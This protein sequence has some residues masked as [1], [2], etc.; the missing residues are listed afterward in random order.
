MKISGLFIIVILAYSGIGYCA[1][2]FVADEAA[3]STQE[4]IK[5]EQQNA[6]RFIKEQV[7]LLAHQDSNVRVT[8]AFT[9]D[10][11]NPKPPII[12]NRE[13]F[14][15]TALTKLLKNDKSEDVRKTSAF[16]ISRIATPK[17][18]DVLF[19]QY[20]VEKNE[21]VRVAMITGSWIKD[22]PHATDLY[23]LGIKDSN[24][25]A[26]HHSAF[27]LGKI[28]E[29]YGKEGFGERYQEVV[30][31]LLGLARNK[32]REEA[33]TGALRA[34]KWF[35]ELKEQSVPILIAN[36]E[37]DDR[38]I[39]KRA[40]ESLGQLRAKQALPLIL[41]D[42]KRSLDDKIPRY[43]FPSDLYLAAAYIGGKEITPILLEAAKKPDYVSRQLFVAF[44][45]LA[46]PRS[47]DFIY[48]YVNKSPPRGLGNSTTTYQDAICAL[49]NLGNTK[50][51]PLLRKRLNDRDKDIASSALVAL[52]NLNADKL[53]KYYDQYRDSNKRVYG[54]WLK[55]FQPR[56][57]P[58]KELIKSLENTNMNTAA[59]G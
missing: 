53:N 54:C 2:N 45:Q 24:Q 57:L 26:Q 23:L 19:A 31:A 43:H 27:K 10:N 42:I 8:A 58:M 37:T 1:S 16:T 49:G 32:M 20:P 15:L 46:D 38:R 39:R 36:L 18:V 40:L 22:L 5:Y 7:D 35:P 30:N 52:T 47:F 12:D 14:A 55:D 33:R 11:F 50:A 13:R 6:D 51:V 3:M 21:E 44:G 41:K 28:K 25:T 9:I 4:K 29:S 56:I 34:L 48:Q 59:Q 17:A